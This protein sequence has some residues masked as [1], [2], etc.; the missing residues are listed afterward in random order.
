MKILAIGYYEK[1]NLG[2]DMLKDSIGLYFKDHNVTF[3]NSDLIEF[4]KLNDYDR[5][6]LGGGDL[7]TDYFIEQFLSVKKNFNKPIWGLGIGIPYESML[8][9][10]GV[11]DIFDCIY[12][13]NLE[14]LPKIQRIIGNDN[15]HYL[16]DLTFRLYEPKTRLEDNGIIGV[17]LVPPFINDETFPILIDTY[18]YLLEKTK[19]KFHFLAFDTD[20]N[21]DNDYKLLNKIK[22]IFPS[23]ERIIID[24]KR[25]T[26]SEM[27]DILGRFHFNILSRFHAHILSILAGV[28]FISFHYAN[29]VNLLMKE[30]S[31][32]YRCNIKV[33]HKDRPIYFDKEEFLSFFF[34]IEENLKET[35]KLLNRIAEK[36][37]FI[38]NSDSL[39]EKIKYSEKR[40]AKTQSIYIDRVDVL[41]QKYKTYLPVTKENSKFLS[42]DMC[43]EITGDIWS[44]YVYGTTENLINKPN[45]LRDMIAWIWKDKRDKKTINFNF[46][47]IDFSSQHRS[48]WPFVVSGIYS[49]N[50]PYNILMDT[51][52]DATFG[53][54]RESPL[55]KRGLIPYTQLWT[56]WFHHVPYL[57]FNQNHLTNV[58]ESKEFKQSLNTCVGIFVLSEYLASW[59]RDKLKE[60]NIPIF[61]LIHPTN[62]E[63][64]IFDDSSF[65]DIKLVNIGGWL[66]NSYSIYE[67]SVPSDIKK[68]K[69]RGKDMDDYFPPSDLFPISLERVEKER[70]NTTFFYSLS[71]YLKR[72]SLDKVSDHISSV[73]V[74]EHLSNDEYDNLLINCVV[75]LDM[76]D[77][78]AINTLIE[79]MARGTPLIIN[80]MPQTEEYLGK[81]YPLFYDNLD[82]VKNLFDRKLLRSASMYLLSIRNK[83]SIENFQKDFLE[84]SKKIKFGLL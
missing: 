18:K 20:S 46:K 30:N 26:S 39:N 42:A 21:S 58:I 34:K 45:E 28:P 57:E 77:C 38:T 22:S 44:P 75:F 4:D 73:T 16:P 83:V 11:M 24:Y 59:F 49:Y 79:C 13:R 10:E 76:I 61:N 5:I 2:D 40:L 81:T 27:L 67:V 14:F 65:K 37:N 63:V 8:E 51:Y 80:R 36:N 29:K 74:L 52:C 72:G 19:Y 15:C 56:G 25:Y 66:R 33:D 78:S 41:Y 54:A 50:N 43:Y 69:L 31:Y 60:Y 32:P 35:E 53:W 9:K 6:I 55:A 64:K 71:E 68:Y 17:S 3:A 47:G 12:I 1:H 70:K 7:I 82:E 62:L 84:C 23:E 48:G